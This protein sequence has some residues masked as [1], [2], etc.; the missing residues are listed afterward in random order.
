MKNIWPKEWGIT[1]LKNVA[2]VATGCYYQQHDYADE[3][4]YEVTT[5]D[6]ITDTVIALNAPKYM[7]I[8]EREIAKFRLKKGDII[9]SHRNS[10]GQIGKS[11]VFELSKMIIH[12]DKFIRIRVTEDYDSGFLN[13]VLKRSK[14]AGLFAEMARQNSH[15]LHITCAQL[16]TLAIP[17]LPISMQHEIMANVLAYA[18]ESQATYI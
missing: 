16:R 14:D 1:E 6:K 15:T 9:L 7:R 10:A 11:V 13:Y 3:H 5:I 12:T 4:L 8:T 2:S 17:S 18:D